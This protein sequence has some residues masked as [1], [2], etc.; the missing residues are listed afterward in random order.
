MELFLVR[1]EIC[2]LNQIRRWVIANKTLL[3]YLYKRLNGSLPSMKCSIKKPT[4]K[5][6]ISVYVLTQA[7]E[8]S[9]NLVDYWGPGL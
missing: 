5:C 1:Q 3:S 7:S 9:N 6:K 8:P 2:K 4:A